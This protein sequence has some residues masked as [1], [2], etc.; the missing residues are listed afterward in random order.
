MGW[1][2]L[3]VIN[4][5]WFVLGMEGIGRRGCMEQGKN[6]YEVYWLGKNFKKR[7]IK[8]KKTVL[9]TPLPLACGPRRVIY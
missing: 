3:A 4:D 5:R 7:T 6:W 2:C 9:A 8:S 1:W